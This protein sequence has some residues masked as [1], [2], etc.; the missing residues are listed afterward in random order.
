MLKW[1]V[2]T[3][4]SLCSI[5]N[6]KFPALL[7]N[8]NYRRELLEL[9]DRFIAGRSFTRVLEVGGID[10]PLITKSPNIRYDGLDIEHTDKCDLIYDNF[11]TQSIESAIPSKYDM[12]ISITLLEHVPDNQASIKSCHETLVNGGAMI[13]YLPSKWHPYA[14]IL[15]IVGPGLQ[16]WI[17]AKLRPDSLKVTGYPAFFDRC[18]P[19]EMKKTVQYAGF[20]NIQIIPFYNATD[21][22]AFFFP[23]YLL[24][25]AWENICYLFRFEWACSGFIFLAFKPNFD[26]PNK[27]PL[28]KSQM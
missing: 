8:G 23:L 27:S 17:I 13:H 24:I 4:R 9:I 10:R 14:V 26:E 20:K 11:Y 19:R 28:N 7:P 5:F 25:L 6:S 21:Y 3:N 22:F 15:R 1:F 16:K 2:K 18:S 12:I